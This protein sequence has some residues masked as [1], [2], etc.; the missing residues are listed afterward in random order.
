MLS[1]DLRRDFD[2]SS[3]GHANAAV[4]AFLV[5]LTAYTPCVAT[6][7]AQRREFGWR[8]ALTG[9]GLQLVFAWVVAVAVFQVLRAIGIG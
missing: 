3:G 6:V 8:W 2:R 7:G 4:L 1:A 5:F 9:V